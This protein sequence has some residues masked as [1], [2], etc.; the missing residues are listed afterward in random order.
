[1]KGNN[2]EISCAPDVKKYRN[3]TY[4]GKLAALS[5]M[6]LSIALVFLKGLRIIHRNYDEYT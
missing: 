6:L 5:S 3:F 1:M 4:R 2:F